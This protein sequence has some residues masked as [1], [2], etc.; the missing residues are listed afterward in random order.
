MRLVLL[1]TL[2]AASASASA[3]AGAQPTVR[4]T[5]R[6]A[7]GAGV[8]GATVWLVGAR[9]PDDSAIAATT[10][11]T[12]AFQFALPYTA[13]SEIVVRRRGLRDARA[14][15]GTVARTRRGVELPAVT[16]APAAPPLVTAVVPDT[17]AFTGNAA[18]FYRRLVARRGDFLTRGELARLKPS[19]VSSALRT[20]PGVMVETANGASYVRLRGSRCFASLWLDGVNVGGGRFDVDAIAPSSLAGIEIYPFPTGLPIEYQSYE[21]TS[22][23]VVALWTQRD[24]FDD[25]PEPATVAEP[26]SVRLASEVDTPARL[27]DGSTFA[28][29]Y[30]AASRAEGIG[31]RVLVE[32]VVDST[33]AVERG[34]VGIV[35]A[36]STDLADP[37]L[38]AASRLR[39]V[40]ARDHGRPV[41]QLVHVVADYRVSQPRRR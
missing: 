36:A 31:G 34:T 4:G 10:D 26:S 12:G 24:G 14:P 25:L 17:G 8:L 27:A 11:A 16:L 29:G 5:V 18:P 21:G 35:A 3:T 15:L 2:V 32:L 33:G 13:S 23:G 40:P 7:D 9:A 28:P 6:T 38:R 39:F 37:A 22:C 41:R 19:R 20:L 1:A 30:P